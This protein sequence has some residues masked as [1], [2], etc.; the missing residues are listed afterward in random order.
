MF[1]PLVS[2]EQPLQKHTPKAYLSRLH[3]D[4]QRETRCSRQ[5]AASCTKAYFYCDLLRTAAERSS[6]LPPSWLQARTLV[7]D[8]HGSSAIPASPVTE[9][10]V[11]NHVH[12]PA[13]AHMLLVHVSCNHRYW[14]NDDR[15][16]AAKPEQRSALFNARFGAAAAAA[17]EQ[18]QQRRK[19]LEADY[20]LLLHQLGV[21]ADSSWSKEVREAVRDAV[22]RQQ[23]QQQHGTADGQPAVE[24]GESEGPA[25]A[26]SDAAAAAAAAVAENG[27][28]SQAGSKAAAAAAAEKAGAEAAAALDEADREDLFR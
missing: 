9:V 4:M 1:A 5:S 25:T 26:G 3:A 27:D 19:Q 11:V 12:N 18:K 10:P 14:S 21:H 20:R 16:E 28:G 13:A 23:G 17:A 15:W 7:C 6:T 2:A 24:E 22:S 8:T